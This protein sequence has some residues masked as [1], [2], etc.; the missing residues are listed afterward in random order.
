[1]NPFG[2]RQQIRSVPDHQVPCEH[3]AYPYQFGILGSKRIRSRVKAALTFRRCVRS[4]FP[5][6]SCISCHFQAMS[7]TILSVSSFFSSGIPLIIRQF[8]RYT[9]LLHLQLILILR[10]VLEGQ[11]FLPVTSLKFPGLSW[12]PD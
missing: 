11:G 6:S 4:I 2:T 3:K 1:M 12:Q 10:F 9:G 7:T 8:L 5:T